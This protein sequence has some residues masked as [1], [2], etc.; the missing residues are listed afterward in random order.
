MRYAKFA[1]LAL[2]LAMTAIA[3]N[4]CESPSQQKNN[5]RTYPQNRPADWE[6]NNGMPGMSF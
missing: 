6:K 5:Y 2:A 4:G 1:I 3:L